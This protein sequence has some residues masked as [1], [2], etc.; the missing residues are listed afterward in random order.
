MSTFF[1][2]NAECWVIF[3]GV[4]YLQTFIS[5]SFKN[6]FHVSDRVRVHVNVIISSSLKPY[7]NL[8]PDLSPDCLLMFSGV[9]PP[10]V[11]DQK[12]RQFQNRQ[13]VFYQ[14]T[15]LMPVAMTHENIHYI[16]RIVKRFAGIS[17]SIMNTYI[18]W[19]F[20]KLVFKVIQNVSEFR[21]PLFRTDLKIR[22]PRF[23]GYLKLPGYAVGQLICSN[24]ILWLGVTI[25]SIGCWL[26]N[27]AYRTRKKIPTVHWDDKR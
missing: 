18:I 27:R 5:T 25:N 13:R 14:V 15:R 26:L 11:H 4:C 21:N 23:R 6:T 12:D 9:L 22:L 3:P 7:Q 24:L 17:F 2:I 20:S 1:C 8:A 16:W 10:V 19:G